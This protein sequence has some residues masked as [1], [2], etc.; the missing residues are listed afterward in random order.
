MYP[1]PIQTTSTLTLCASLAICA[2]LVGTSA[3]AQNEPP[4]THGRGA[5]AQHAIK[6]P[7]IGFNIPR[8]RNW[9]KL[10]RWL[11]GQKLESKA[12]VSVDIS[13]P[14]LLADGAHLFDMYCA[15]CHGAQ[16]KGDGPRA[17]GLEP[18][19]RDLA[20]GM[21]KF[22][23]TP[24]GEPPTS[25][26]LFQTIS[27]GLRG[28][29]MLPFADLA[30]SQ[31][32]ALVAHVSKLANLQAQD[33]D[34][35]PL[36]VPAPQQGTSL[37]DRVA[38]GRQFYTKLG[39]DKCHGLT[40]RGDGPS[41]RDQ[42]DAYGRPMVPRDFVTQALKRGEYPEDIYQSIATGL[43]GT[44]MPGYLE[45]AASEEIWD[46]VAFVSSL[47]A[48]GFSKVSALELARARELVNIQQGR[49]RHAVISG[50]GCS[51]RR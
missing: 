29:G 31:R 15:N 30:E 4:D 49:G 18:R 27:G 20:S 39:C 42:V 43:D 13:D 41:A 47:P 38:R 40:G 10:Q 26:D 1:L 5:H 8:E 28:T 2:S 46:L 37:R 34:Q 35:G 6:Q 12:E 23:S 19:P 48:Q 9:I 21:F 36:D 45:S 51:S 24:S 25:Q 32:W 33:S 17:D 50:C 14:F 7:D 3:V 16:G 22:R 44:P 11:S